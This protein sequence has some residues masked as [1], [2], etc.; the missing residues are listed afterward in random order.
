MASDEKS[1]FDTSLSKKEVSELRYAFDVFET[2]E[3]SNHILTKN[4]GKV[5]RSL[6]QN[7]MSTDIQTMQNELDEVGIGRIAF[8]KFLKAMEEK[9][10]AHRIDQELKN[11]F[12]VFDKGDTGF[13]PIK[14]ICTVLSVAADDIPQKDLDDMARDLDLNRDGR[15]DYQEFLNMM[16]HMKRD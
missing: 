8:P 16:G 12:R 13:V 2:F 15:L 14:E 6:G 10:K 9:M 5:L 3:G 1:E 4:L 11:A 7:M